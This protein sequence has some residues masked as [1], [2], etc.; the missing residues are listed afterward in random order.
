MF[1]FQVYVNK[2]LTSNTTYTLTFYNLGN[3]NTT[4]HVNGIPASLIT[5][6]GGAIRIQLEFFNGTLLI[7]GYEKKN[8]VKVNIYFSLAI[9]S[10][11]C[12]VFSM[13]IL[14]C[15]VPCSLF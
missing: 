3:S 6:T 5:L 13:F 15:S 8:E 10:C 11:Y 9:S 12:N 2:K 4:A 7:G 14:F 1:H